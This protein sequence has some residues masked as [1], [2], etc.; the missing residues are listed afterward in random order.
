MLIVGTIIAAIAGDSVGYWFGKKVGPRI[1]K[2][3]ESLFF[4]KSY[5][6]KTQEFFNKHGKKTI[7]LARFVPIVRTFAPIMA[8]VGMM[9]YKN[10][11]F[12]NVIGGVA[13][14]LIFGLAGAFLG[15]VLPESEKYL[16][17]ITLGIVAVSLIPAL[18][19]VLRIAR[20][21]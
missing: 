10:F 17:Y 7:A 1:F 9:E 16:A 6:V 11:L 21:R 19:Q 14:V 2:K 13:W 12:W 5:I 3:E 15:N 18:F 8:G 20:N 4:K